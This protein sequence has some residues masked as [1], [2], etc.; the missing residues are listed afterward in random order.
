MRCMPN[1]QNLLKSEITRIAR[2][3]IKT[4]VVRLH[5]AASKY[6]SEIAAL[7]RRVD[8][9]EKSVKRASK[10]PADPKLD[11]QDNVAKK[12]HRFSA[13]RLAAQRKRLK[14]SAAEMGK[15]LGV[16][17]LSVYAWETGKTRPRDRHL[18]AISALG[19]LKPAQAAE[20]AASR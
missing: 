5:S 14:L 6:R 7:K 13:I 8:T 17:N 15:L 18:P 4:E 11:T 2:K 12:R 9:L 16:S 20:I 1:I 10:V 3:E 19:K